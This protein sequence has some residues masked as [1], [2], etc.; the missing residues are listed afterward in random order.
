MPE[1]I[2]KPQR[3]RRIRR[4]KPLVLR[5]S[6]ALWIVFYFV[7]A[8]FFWGMRPLWSPDEGRYAEAARGMM[9]YGSGI[10]P[11]LFAKP[12]LTK[13]PVTYWAIAAGMELLGRN[14]WG[15]RLFLAGAFFGT[16]LAVV[17]L[18]RSWG[19]SR[20]NRYLAG[21]I[22]CT[23][24]LPFAAGNVLTTDMFLTFFMT[25]GLAAAWRVWTGTRHPEVWRG[26]FWLSFAMAFLTKGPPGWL[27]LLGLAL[28]WFLRPSGARGSLWSWRWFVAFLMVSA[29]WYAALMIRDAT[30][31]E[32]FL[33]DEVLDRV[34]TDDHGRENPPWIYSYILLGGVFPWVFLWPAF[35]RRAWGSIRGG[36]RQ[37]GSPELFSVLW[38]GTSLLVFCISKSRMP[39]YVLPLF[40]PLAIWFGKLL[41]ASGVWRWAAHNATHRKVLKFAAGAWIVILMVSRLVPEWGAP[42]RT[43]LRFTRELERWA[44]G[45]PDREHFF[46]RE[47]PIS[48][49]IPFYLDAEVFALHIGWGDLTD[50]VLEHQDPGTRAVFIIENDDSGDV[51][52]FA[53]NWEVLAADHKYLA[54][55]M[56]P[57]R[58]EELRSLP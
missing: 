43:H 17:T 42:E 39:L 22:F 46:A 58:L 34:L 5:L 3:H 18:A 41:P 11:H 6:P 32:Y 47:R 1:D 49:L 36:Y 48:A 21:G 9:Q 33:K 7:A 44:E 56:R 2:A 8:F 51:P 52:E 27:S 31:V 28:F 10:V 23:S 53:T 40:V 57:N 30:L 50:W 12:H 37:M 26:V 45:T 15:A 38:F 14:T 13:P 35:F 54:I 4:R 19:W 20:R 55:G 25:L 16:I 24:A 29:S